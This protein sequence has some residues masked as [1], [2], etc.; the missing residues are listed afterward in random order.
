MWAQYIIFGTISVYTYMYLITIG[1]KRGHG[2]EGNHGG[3][4]YMGRF[5]E[6]KGREKYCN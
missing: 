6:M 4:W 5:G 3:V 1:E 2:F